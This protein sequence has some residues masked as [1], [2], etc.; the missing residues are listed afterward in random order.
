MRNFITVSE[1]EFNAAPDGS[2]HGS[3][4]ARGRG[5]VI[6]DIGL[7]LTVDVWSQQGGF[8]CRS[9]R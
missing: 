8:A 6:N 7:S 9:R 4:C 3:A 1:I 2:M 5:V